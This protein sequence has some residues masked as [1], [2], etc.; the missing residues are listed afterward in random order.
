MF[1]ESI[2]HEY[3]LINNNEKIINAFKSRK[4]YTVYGKCHQLWGHIFQRKWTMNEK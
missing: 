4:P 3:W 1:C 2:M